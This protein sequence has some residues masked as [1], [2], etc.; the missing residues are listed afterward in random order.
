MINT[1]IAPAQ[2]VPNGL[3]LLKVRE[4]VAC[5]AQLCDFEFTRFDAQELI[6]K[7]A[8]AALV[9][10]ADLV[11]IVAEWAPISSQRHALRLAEL[12]LRDFHPPR[13]MRRRGAR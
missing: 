3:A 10:A 13:R 1:H 6:E 4:A 7:G 8:M 12:A 11:D 9:P 2:A 5:A